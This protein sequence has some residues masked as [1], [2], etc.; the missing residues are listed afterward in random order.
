MLFESI[1]TSTI[2]KFFGDHTDGFILETGSGCEEWAAK[3]AQL[4]ND[5]MIGLEI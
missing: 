5:G 3:T 2:R 1:N 4:I